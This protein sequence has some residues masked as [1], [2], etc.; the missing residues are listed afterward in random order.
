MILRT[1]NIALHIH[2]HIHIHKNHNT[3]DSK[4]NDR[5]G[6]ASNLKGS[7]SFNVSQRIDETRR[8]I[9]LLGFQPYCD[10]YNHILLRDWHLVMVKI[11]DSFSKAT[12]RVEL[13]LGTRRA[14]LSSVPT[15]D[16]RSRIKRIDI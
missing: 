4:V 6:G 9:K 10:A 15:N 16:C 13:E 3:S 11:P 2:I 8:C 14:I 1:L 5:R 12:V 7:V